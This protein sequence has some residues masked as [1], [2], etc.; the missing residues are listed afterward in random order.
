MKINLLVLLSI[1]LI[2]TPIFAQQY[3]T[4]KDPRDGRVYKTV[5][6]GNQEWMAE[7]LNADRFMNGDLI[8]HGKTN[9]QWHS[10]LTS[11]KAAWCNFENNSSYS[12]KYGKLYNYFAVNDSRG[13]APPGWHIAKEEEWKELIAYLEENGLSG[14]SLKKKSFWKNEKQNKDSTDFAALPSGARFRTGEFL[15]NE[16][17]W[18]GWIANNETEGYYL[19]NNN[20]RIERFKEKGMGVSVRCVKD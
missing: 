2:S 10:A 18:F 11:K 4:F 5:K 15:T 8:Q 3:G 16:E 19:S 13:L 9:E 1:L 17:Y 7:N 12:Q 14:S 20:N 6:I